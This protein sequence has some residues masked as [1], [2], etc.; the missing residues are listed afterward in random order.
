VLESRI[1]RALFRWSLYIAA[2][3]VLM[4]MISLEF[5]FVVWLGAPPWF[6]HVAMT[7]SMLAVFV[8]VVGAVGTMICLL[9]NSTRKR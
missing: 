7:L 9:D 6:M 2:A 4:S 5:T 3:S 8:S 1:V